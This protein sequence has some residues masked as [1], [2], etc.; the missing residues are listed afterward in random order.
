MNSADLP[1]RD[2]HLPGDVSWWPPAP[3]WWLLLLLLAAGIAAAL[4]L[5]RRYRRRALSRAVLVELK[6][7]EA[8]YQRQLD[9]K[10]LATELS[11][12]L[13]RTSISLKGRQHIAALSGEAWLAWL[14]QEAGTDQFKNGPGQHLL[15]APY[16]SQPEFYPDKLIQLCRRWLVTVPPRYIVRRHA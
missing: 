11:A 6:K 5:Y 1:L 9:L 16:Q 3:G 2:I 7:I 4:Y 12:L 15:K 14:D 13:R 8:Q 10:Q